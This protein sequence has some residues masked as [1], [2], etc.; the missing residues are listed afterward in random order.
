MNNLGQVT[1]ADIG[2]ALK[3]YQPFIAIVVAVLLVVAFLPGQAPPGGSVTAGDVEIADIGSGGSTVDAGGSDGTDGSGATGVEGSASGGTSASSGGSSSS[4]GGR[5]AAGTPGRG[6]STQAAVSLPDR[7][8]ANCDASRGRIALPVHVSPPCTAA[9]DGDNGGTTYQGVTADTIKVVVYEPQA[10]AAVDA[11]LTAAGAN[12]TPEQREATRNGFNEIFNA[13]YN[14][15]GRKVELVHYQASG[16]SDDDAAAKADAIEIATGLKAFAVINA[17]GSNAFPKEL[18]ARGVLCI[19]TASQPNEFYESLDPYVGYTSLPSS[20]QGYVHR[21]EY[22][23]KRLANGRKAVH[24]GDPTLQLAERK[25]GI[26]YFETADNAYAG[27]VDFFEGLLAQCGVKLAVRLGYT[28]PPDLAT[29]QEQAR[30]FIQKMKDEGVTSVIFS[31]DFLSPA[32]FTQEATR[33]RYTPEWIITGSVLTDTTIFA[34]TYDKAQWA[35]AFGISY[36]TARYPD[37]EGDVFNLYQWHHGRTPEADNQFG[38]LYAGMLPL[39]LGMML[40]GETLTPQSFQAGLFAFPPTGGGMK[41]A[42]HISWGHHG[43]WG[44]MRDY[45]AV[46]NVAEIWWDNTATGEDEVGNPGTGMYR[47]VNGG[48]RYL[49]GQHPTGDTTA[50]NPEG[51]VTVYDT[52]PEEERA[53]QYPPP[54]R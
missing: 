36:L 10:N 8:V 31:G 15:W 12:N 35:H 43:I 41:T 24:A 44:D 9:Y 27:G 39:Y 25:F 3:R 1:L 47:Y 26:L 33:Q 32:I 20:T 7:P 37:E 42:S 14:L 4:G 34:R 17:P 40:A 13:H 19:C 5:S 2:R 29:T 54:Q 52:R 38:V 53:P 16:P 30:P 21:A 6:G 28:G 50:F 51:T 46:D 11:A 23:C 49:P 18:A 22:I 48:E 45:T